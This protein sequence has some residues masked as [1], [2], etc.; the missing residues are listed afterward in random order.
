MKHHWFRP[1]GWIY[2]PTRWQGWLVTALAALWCI[3]I[4]IAVDRVARSGS[5]ALYGSFPFVV[6]AFLLWLWV[7]SKTSV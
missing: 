2:A 5:D 3:H 1:L 6:P 7:A 4:F